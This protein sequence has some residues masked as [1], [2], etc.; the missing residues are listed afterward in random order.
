MNSIR[1][2][3]LAA[4]RELAQPLMQDIG[5]KRLYWR[6]KMCL[7][8]MHERWLS[9]GRLPYRI[10]EARLAFLCSHVSPNA[11]ALAWF[12]QGVCWTVSKFLLHRIETEN[13][14]SV[15]ALGGGPGTELLAIGRQ[16]SRI[17]QELPADSEPPHISFITHEAETGW[18]PVFNRV[19]DKVNN[20][21]SQRRQFRLDPIPSCIH[22]PLGSPLPNILP[23]DL[24]LLSYV[25]SENDTEVA[26]ENLRQLLLPVVDAAPDNSLFILTDVI[27]DGDLPFEP[28]RQFLEQLGLTIQFPQPHGGSSCYIKGLRNPAEPPSLMA[29]FYE[30]IRANGWN[31]RKDSDVFWLVA[32]KSVLQDEFHEFD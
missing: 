18:L 20:A 4:L 16:L 22:T 15:W 26:R 14:L 31:L 19:C 25:M 12:M 29:E 24:Y 13:M 5:E 30:G 27:P 32:S 2:L 3:V 23:A 1:P 11:D 7:Q 21:V 8:V 10:A 28:A 6:M 9:G 17:L